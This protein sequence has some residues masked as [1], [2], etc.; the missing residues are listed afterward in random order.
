[1][2]RATITAMIGD[3][4]ISRPVI[5]LVMCRSASDSNA[6]G[7]MISIVANATSGRQCRSS[8]RSCPLRR[9]SG[10]STAA[11]TAVRANTR[12]GTDTPSTATLIMRYGTPQM[13]LISA[14]RTH[15]RALTSRSSASRNRFPGDATSAHG[16]A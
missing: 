13:T 1:V 12:T 4:A 2:A 3:A 7:T 8:P 6:Q 5:E 11:P 10:S 14:N 9:A 15:P 16:P